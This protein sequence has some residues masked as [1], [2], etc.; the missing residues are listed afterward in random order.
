MWLGWRHASV[1]DGLSAER[2]SGPGRFPRLTGRNPDQ[3]QCLDKVLNLI[4]NI[5]NQL[6]CCPYQKARPFFVLW[7]IL[8]F[9]LNFHANRSW[10]KFKP[11]QGCCP[12]WK[13]RR[14]RTSVWSWTRRSSST[15]T[16]TRRTSRPLPERK[17]Q[18]WKIFDAWRHFRRP[19]MQF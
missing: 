6:L 8:A 16:P 19:T 3:A 15:A 5:I 2:N 18:K 7:N 17:S 13:T 9:W 1:I 10:L 14:G 4:I 11:A 12:S